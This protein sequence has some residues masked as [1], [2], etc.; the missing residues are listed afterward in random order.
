MPN[1]GDRF[2]CNGLCVEARQTH[3]TI[4]ILPV[5]LKPWVSVARASGQVPQNRKTTAGSGCNPCSLSDV[6][7]YT[8]LSDCLL[9]AIRWKI[10]SFTVSY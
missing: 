3:P 10:N 8:F 7:F 4:K 1:G 9:R 6:L 2:H 5:F